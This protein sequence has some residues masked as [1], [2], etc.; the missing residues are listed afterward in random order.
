MQHLILINDKDN[1]ATA[2]TELEKGFEYKIET[3][4]SNSITVN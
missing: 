3:L 4:E 1:V 2:T